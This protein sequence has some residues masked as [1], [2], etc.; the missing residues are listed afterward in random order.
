M[1][2]VT[3]Y[4]ELIALNKALFEAR[5]HADPNH[6]EVP[7]SPFVAAIHERVL[8]AIF[9]HDCLPQSKIDAFLK[10]SNRTN[11]H[12][13]VRRHLTDG[14]WCQMDAVTQRECVIVLVRPFV[15][16]ESEINALIEFAQNDHDTK[17]CPRCS[18]R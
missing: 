18:V 13:A 2:E 5:Y 10:W 12:A 9:A 7:A 16:T 17:P 8:A 3:D 11:E 6:R 1:F 4:Y 15:A 14:N